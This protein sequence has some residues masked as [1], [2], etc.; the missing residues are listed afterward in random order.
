[1][2]DASNLSE[3]RIEEI[4]DFY[5]SSKK[6][7]SILEEGS[8]L[9]DKKASGQSQFLGLP[10]W[11]KSKEA[12]WKRLKAKY[13]NLFLL[14]QINLSEVKD[15]RLPQSGYLQFFVFD[16][17]L[18]E[19]EVDES[20][21]NEDVVGTNKRHVTVYHSKND[22]MNGLL[23]NV[24]DIAEDFK[25]LACNF[26]VRLGESILNQSL[27]EQIEDAG[28]EDASEYLSYDEDFER[29]LNNKKFST[30]GLKEKVQE[31]L[32]LM[33]LS[34]AGTSTFGGHPNFCQYDERVEGSKMTE[35]LLRLESTER[36]MYG[37]MGNIHIFTTKESLE[38]IEQESELETYYLF[39]C[40]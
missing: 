24:G 1:M 18:W 30:P 38:R 7:M 11:P 14:A 4:C 39:Q 36:M 5:I 29:L 21:N 26:N 33:R 32:R 3:K 2:K 25:G 19:E 35:L 15:S 8:N 12:L 23:L 13:G 40:H 17:E 20:L 31:V 28:F 10:Y 22:Y 16:E 6:Q 34:D 37:D 27:Y 9:S